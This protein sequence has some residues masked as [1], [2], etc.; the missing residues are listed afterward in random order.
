MVGIGRRVHH[1]AVVSRVADLEYTSAFLRQAVQHKLALLVS[2][3]R[4]LET[5]A[6]KVQCIVDGARVAVVREVHARDF[7]QGHEPQHTDRCSGGRTSLFINDAAP[8]RGSQ[9]QLKIGGPAFRH[10]SPGDGIS[11]G[12]NDQVD[13]Q[14]FLPENTQRLRLNILE[15]K[16][17][18]V[19]GHRCCQIA[20]RR[21]RIAPPTLPTDWVFAQINLGSGNGFA[22]SPCDRAEYRVKQYHVAFFKAI[23]PSQCEQSRAVL[24]RRV[25]LLRDGIVAIS[26]PDLE[27]RRRQYQPDPHRQKARDAPP[28]QTKART[29][30]TG[31][32]EDA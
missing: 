8:H 9:L 1:F 30:W 17:P 29:R 32:V 13:R 14:Y 2:G 27:G 7:R 16:L 4:D 21:G 25:H 3:G 31:R 10:F 18:L 11:L 28:C 22:T 20:R 26:N 5:G 12:H 6:R 24:R 23:L 15:A 19:I